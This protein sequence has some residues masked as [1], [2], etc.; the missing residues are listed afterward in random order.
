M[1]AARAIVALNH[2]N[3]STLYDVGLNYLVME[4][5]EGQPGIAQGG[6]F[7]RPVDAWNIRG[8]SGRPSPFSPYSIS[9]TP[10]GVVRRTKRSWLPE[11]GYAFIPNAQAGYTTWDEYLQNQKKLS[12]NATQRRCPRQR[13]PRHEGP[14]LLPGLAF[15]G[16]CSALIWHGPHD[17]I[18]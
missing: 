16:K 10:G 4:Y 15:C 1:R 8:E 5:I 12:E 18:R 2:P 3:I 6:R 9:A 11:E 13:M 14:A 17:S 7:Q